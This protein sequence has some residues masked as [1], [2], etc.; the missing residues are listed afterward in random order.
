M[1]HLQKTTLWL[2][3]L[4]AMAGTACVM[5]LLLQQTT[6][7]QLLFKAALANSLSGNC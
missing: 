3:A 5:L 1:I 4:F 2:A 7:G 6:D